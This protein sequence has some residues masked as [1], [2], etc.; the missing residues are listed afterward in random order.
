MAMLQLNKL[1]KTTEKRKRVGRGGDRGGHSGRGKDGQKARTG[2]TSELKA[3]FE[4]GQMPLIRR[5]PRRGFN[6][7]FKKQFQLVKLVDLET[8]FNNGETVNEESLRQK[9]LVKGKKAF[10]IKI[11]AAGPQDCKKTGAGAF[12]KK[13]TVHVDAASE[14]ASQAILKAGGVVQLI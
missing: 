10:L 13:L 12:T 2:S 5:I 1:E 6:N 11:V 7:V 9:G 4:G 8:K 3:Y 14:S